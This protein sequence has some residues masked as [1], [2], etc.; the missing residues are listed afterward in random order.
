MEN[1]YNSIVSHELEICAIESDPLPPYFIEETIN[2]DGKTRVHGY[3]D[4]DE[5]KSD[6]ADFKA[7]MTI[8]AAALYGNTDD[9]GPYMLDVFSHRNA[10]V[11]TEYTCTFVESDKENKD[12]FVEWLEMNSIDFHVFADENGNDE[13]HVYCVTDWQENATVEWLIHH[14]VMKDE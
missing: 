3:Y 14:G 5:A 1:I 10:Y 6:F 9:D 12:L 2:Y 7:D 4:L 11:Q 8:I 13:L